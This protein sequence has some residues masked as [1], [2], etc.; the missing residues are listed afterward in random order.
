[1]PRSPALGRWRQSRLP[2]PQP[3]VLHSALSPLL[4]ALPATR[5]LSSL[6]DLVTSLLADL[7]IPKFCF[8][9]LNPV[10]SLRLQTAQALWHV[11]ESLLSLLLAWFLFLKNKVGRNKE[12]VHH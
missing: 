5:L 8:P 4:L 6:R 7:L 3:R 10:V 12:E 11:G 1:M 9:A 2:F